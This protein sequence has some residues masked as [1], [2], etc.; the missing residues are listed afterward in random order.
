MAEAERINEVSEFHLVKQ[1]KT[2][3]TASIFNRY[4]ASC[5]ETKTFTRSLGCPGG[6]EA[7]SR[8]RQNRHSHLIGSSGPQSSLLAELEKM[9]DSPFSGTEKSSRCGGK[10]STTRAKL[11]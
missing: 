11:R 6:G 4:S 9:A 7:L 1:D 5:P 10:K 3:S 8:R 2:H